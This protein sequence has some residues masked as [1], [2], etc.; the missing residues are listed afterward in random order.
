LAN[1]ASA[2]KAH[3][4]SVRRRERNRNHTSRLRTALKRVSELIKSG[5]ADEAKAA[6]PGLYALVDKSVQKKVLSPNAARRHKSRF[7]LAVNA[8]R[9]GGA[10]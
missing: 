7:T 4:Q 6:L 10:K 8:G 3:R 2:L 1:H 5:K 9:A